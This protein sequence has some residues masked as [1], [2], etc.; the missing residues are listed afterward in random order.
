M[1]VVVQTP[2]L[3]RENILHLA[4]LEYLSTHCVSV[5]VGGL[6]VVTKKGCD[7]V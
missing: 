1:R 7:T 6:S 2:T 5:T 4:A 3:K